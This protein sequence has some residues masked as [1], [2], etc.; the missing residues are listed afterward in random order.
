ME[1]H[2]A[3]TGGP[4]HKPWVATQRGGSGGY[5]RA[6]KSSAA[7]Y[8][9]IITTRLYQQ[10]SLKHT[11]HCQHDGRSLRMKSWW[12]KKQAGLP[13]LRPCFSSAGVGW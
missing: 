12:S 1:K 8:G 9:I 5:V 3:K 2:L 13:P 11:Y 10:I 4:R 6:W 7:V